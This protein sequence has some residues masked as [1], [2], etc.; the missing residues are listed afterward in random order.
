MAIIR[1]VHAVHIEQVATYI[2][3]MLYKSPMPMQH[4]AIALRCGFLKRL[5]NKLV[6]HTY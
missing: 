1:V 4:L 2:L 6:M 5:E 3:L